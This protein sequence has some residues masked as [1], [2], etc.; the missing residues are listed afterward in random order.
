MSIQARSASKGDAYAST[1]HVEQDR[2]PNFLHDTA[3]QASF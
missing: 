2:L 1:M 3:R